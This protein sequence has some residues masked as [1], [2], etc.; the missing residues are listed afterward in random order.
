MELMTVV[1]ILAIIAVCGMDAI[2]E[3]ETAQRADRAARESLAYFRLARTLAMSTGKKAKVSV[4][5]SSKTVSVFW[6]SNGSAYDATAYASGMTAS[7]R[8]V[9]DLTNSRELTGTTVSLNPSA[10]T[11]FEYSAL[12]TCQQTGT[13]T[14]TYGG[15]TKSI[16]VVAVGDPQLQ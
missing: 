16:S 5:T 12:G 4:S 13:V 6:Q 3:F 10:T 1:L 15:K 8:C 7:G 9:L 14:F 11:D 2:A